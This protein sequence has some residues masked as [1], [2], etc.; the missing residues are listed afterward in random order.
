MHALA[1]S[2]AVEADRAI[3]SRD[4]TEYVSRARGLD[5]SSDGVLAWQA[6][7]SRMPEGAQRDAMSRE[8]ARKFVVA[9]APD[10][11]S[12]RPR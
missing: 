9:W 1:S 10:R 8:L 5:A 6:L 12:I 11:R 3:A 2:L 4:V 7:V